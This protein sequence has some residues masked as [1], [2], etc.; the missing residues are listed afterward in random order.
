MEQLAGRKICYGAMSK[1]SGS[2]CA[3]VRKF[4]S[5]PNLLMPYP[6]IFNARIDGRSIPTNDFISPTLQAVGSRYP[7]HRDRKLILHLLNC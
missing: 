3:M 6:E 7:T 5:G 4:V 1:I 2:T